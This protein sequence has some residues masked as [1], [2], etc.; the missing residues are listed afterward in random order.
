MGNG[1]NQRFSNMWWHHWLILV[2]ALFTVRLVHILPYYY[3]NPTSWLQ[4][5]KMWLQQEGSISLEIFRLGF[6]VLQP[7]WKA[8]L[9]TMVGEIFLIL[10]L[11][12]LFG[13]EW[14]RQQSRNS[15]QVHGLSCWASLANITL[16]S[17]CLSACK[18]LVSWVFRRIY[19]SSTF[20]IRSGLY[21]QFSCMKKELP[22][23]KSYGYRSAAPSY[24]PDGW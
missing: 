5:Y 4:T 18:V 17:S 10:F 7:S 9:L 3:N 2:T 16:V 22:S 11:L 12:S 15:K 13:Y 21:Y 14:C 24:I 19:P 1:G 23:T 20:Q 8:F 6:L